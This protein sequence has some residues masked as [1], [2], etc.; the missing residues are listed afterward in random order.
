MNEAASARHDQHQERDLRESHEQEPTTS[1]A[2][3]ASADEVEAVQ[4]ADGATAAGQ[5]EPDAAGGEEERHEERHV[6]ERQVQEL[7]GV[8][9]DRESD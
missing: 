8:P 9:Q 2:P 5:R 6:Q 1:T 4:P 3:V 7:P